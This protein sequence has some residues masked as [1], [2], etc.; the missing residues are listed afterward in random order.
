MKQKKKS[1]SG[2]KI[3]EIIADDSYYLHRIALSGRYNDSLYEISNKWS[4]DELMKAL[5]WINL[6]ETIEEE[7]AKKMEAQ[8]KG[9]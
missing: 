8:R 6:Y 4:L 9:R 2:K 1:G 3:P 7:Q 5:E